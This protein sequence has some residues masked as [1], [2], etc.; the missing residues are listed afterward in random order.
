MCVWKSL[1]LRVSLM[2]TVGFVCLLCN[3]A[4]FSNKAAFRSLSISSSQSGAEQPS[5]TCRQEF[6]L[7]SEQLTPWLERK[8]TPQQQ[9]R[10]ILQPLLRSNCSYPV[11]VSMGSCTVFFSKLLKDNPRRTVNWKFWEE[12][13]R[14]WCSFTELAFSPFHLCVWG[15]LT[16]CC[17][18]ALKS[19]Q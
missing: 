13:E 18:V 3:L 11:P 7:N 8:K 5:W 12:N 17:R 1:R 19:L 10:I 4:A 14:T 16:E 2:Q 15:H 6:I 9:R